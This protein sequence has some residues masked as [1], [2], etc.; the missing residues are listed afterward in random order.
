M[1]DRVESV[2]R[3][4]QQ[5]KPKT[6]HYFAAIEHRVI[7]SEAYRSMSFSARALLTLMAR[8]LTN[9]NNGQLQASFKWCRE[10]GFG[11][12]H[13]LRNALSELITCGFIYRTRSHGANG[14]WAR[15]A[16]TWLPIKNRDGLFLDG[17]MPCAWRYWQPPQKKS[18]RQKV[19]DQSSRKCSFTP[20]D[21]AES[22]GKP[23]AET[24]EYELI[25]YTQ[26]ITAMFKGQWSAFMSRRRFTFTRPFKRIQFSIRIEPKAPVRYV[27]LN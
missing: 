10:Y 27:T 25:P 8:Q 2:R 18:S 16:V 11:S 5:R 17:F 22:A 9:D 24:A 12:E 4:H 13:T 23:P 21:P 6:K 19:P 7:D 26:E 15:Y 14:A 1:Q 3:G 20:K